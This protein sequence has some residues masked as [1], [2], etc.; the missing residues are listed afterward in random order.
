MI[1]IRLL[2]M[3]HAAALVVFVATVLPNVEKVIA[4]QTVMKR[5]NVDLTPKRVLK[6]AL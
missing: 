6:H 2:L 4:L 1:A 3:P 5:H